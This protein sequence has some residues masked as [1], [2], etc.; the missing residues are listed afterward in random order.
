MGAGLIRQVSLH[1]KFF[2]DLQWSFIDT[3]IL[4]LFILVVVVVVIIVVFV[5]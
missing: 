2:T 1:I 4:L 5:V 3:V